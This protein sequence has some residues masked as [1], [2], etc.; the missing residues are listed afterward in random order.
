MS[1]TFNDTP[2]RSYRMSQKT[3]LLLDNLDIM[4]PGKTKTELINIA[5]SWLVLTL[6]RIKAGDKNVTYTKAL[7]DV[8]NELAEI[9]YQELAKTLIPD[10][11][12]NTHLD[13]FIGKNLIEGQEETDEDTE[14]EK[15]I[16]EF[17]E[18]QKNVGNEEGEE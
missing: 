14:F 10:R 5:V 18:I 3:R 15:E 16:E 2:N 7:E 8:L 1:V 11:R 9:D 4:I 6:K 13:D 12:Y 17:N